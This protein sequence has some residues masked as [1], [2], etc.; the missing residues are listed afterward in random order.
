MVDIISKLYTHAP[1]Y[2]PEWGSGGI[3]G[4]RY[5]RGVLY[6]TLAF[7]ARSFFIREDSVREYTFDLVGKPPV[8][9]G[10]TYN[11]VDAVDDMI[12]FGGWVHA[13]AKY[14]VE[15]GVRKIDFSNKYSHVHLYRISDDRVEL[16]WKESVHEKDK[17]VGEVSEIIYDPVNDRLLLA[18]GDGMVNL[19]IYAL[20][21]RSKRIARLSSKPVLKGTLVREHACFNVHVFGFTGTESIQCIDLVSNTISEHDIPKSGERVVDNGVVNT[22]LTGAMSYSYIHCFCS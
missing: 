10:D 6:Y 9:G 22:P 5:H 14:V 20:D 7:E 16:L 8:S 18:R 2:G 13:P 17:W 15:Q 19:G 11:A 3:F 1:R 12:F 4:L 21:Y